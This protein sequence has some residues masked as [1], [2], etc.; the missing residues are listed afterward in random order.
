MKTKFTESPI[1]KQYTVGITNVYVLENDWQVLLS[2]KDDGK[3]CCHI[4]NLNNPDMHGSTVL[5][6]QTN[7]LT[8]IIRNESLVT[9]ISGLVESVY[10][11]HDKK[12]NNPF[13]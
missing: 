9:W 10:I 1:V 7:D 3:I 4:Q 2:K 8:E 13:M 11:M 5:C 12:E 6:C